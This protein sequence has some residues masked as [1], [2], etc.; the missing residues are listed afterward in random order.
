M[1]S[2]SDSHSPAVVLEPAP[3]AER[4]V[5][6]DGEVVGLVVDQDE[7]AER[8]DPVLVGDR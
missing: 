4:P 3:A 1:T 7:P 5:R 6:R 2:V 8:R